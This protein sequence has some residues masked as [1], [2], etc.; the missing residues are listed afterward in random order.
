MNLAGVFWADYFTTIAGMMFRTF[1]QSFDNFHV[2][3]DCLAHLHS[4]TSR[5][6]VRCPSLVNPLPGR[7]DQKSRFARASIGC[8][9][10]LS[11][12]S[13]I[14]AGILRTGTKKAARLITLP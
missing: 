13:V 7:L 2:L 5:T 8:A 4:G 14:A 3:G 10:H 12:I 11:T 9:F 6:T 1:L